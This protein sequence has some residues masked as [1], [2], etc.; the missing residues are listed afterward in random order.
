[1]PEA[2]A[3]H[4]MSLPP[5]SRLRE[6]SGFWRH[7]ELLLLTGFGSGL[8]RRAPGTA[9]SAVAVLL[10]WWC[11]ADLS[12][13]VQGCVVIGVFLL[14]VWL[15]ERAA[16]KFGVG[17]DP[18]IVI[19]E[20]AGQWLALLGAPASPAAV[21]AGFVLFRLF[22]IAKPWPISVADQRVHGGLGVMLDDL[23]AGGFAL[24]GMVLLR[25]VGWV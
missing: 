12:W 7:P 6:L 11:L 5:V 23:L 2:R 18:A 10:W 4:T 22:D 24:A 19:D 8:A 13:V 3:R 14:G 16:R 25:E 1:M 21:L 17:D 9:G 20:F 15:A